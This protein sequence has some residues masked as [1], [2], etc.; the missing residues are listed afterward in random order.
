MMSLKF[1]VQLTISAI[2][3]I[4][5]CLKGLCFEVNAWNIMNGVHNINK[6]KDDT[7]LSMHVGLI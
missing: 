6:C 7:L 2:L 3:R 1:W 5:Y 4:W